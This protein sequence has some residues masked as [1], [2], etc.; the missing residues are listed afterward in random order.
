MKF[1]KNERQQFYQEAIALLRELGATDNPATDVY[2]Y[3]IETKVGTLRLVVSLS[4]YTGSLG[5][6]F[7]RF[8]NPEKAAKIVDCNPYSGKW[9]FHFFAVE[10]WDTDTALLHFRQC[11]GKITCK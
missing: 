9:N 10:G 1:T 6:V 3:S 8:R 4:D 2:D 7:G 5:T 11:I